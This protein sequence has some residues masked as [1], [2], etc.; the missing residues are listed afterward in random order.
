[1]SASD[2]SPVSVFLGSTYGPI[3][4]GIAGTFGESRAVTFLASRPRS[5]ES[6]RA[7]AGVYIISSLLYLEPWHLLHSMPQFLLIAPS[8]TNILVRRRLTLA[9]ALAPCPDPLPDTRQNVYA[10]CNLHD[11][12]W[13]TKGSDKVEALPAA[14]SKS[15]GEEKVVETHERVQEGASFDARLLFLRRVPRG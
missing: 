6:F 5:N 9:S 4:A 14:K 3:F 13:G 10:F 2:A 7:R 15:D 1:M 11:V 8:F 12:S